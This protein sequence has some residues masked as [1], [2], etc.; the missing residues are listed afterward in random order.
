MRERKSCR[1][2]KVKLDTDDRKNRNIGGLMREDKEVMGGVQERRR[3][4]KEVRK[5][6]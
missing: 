3:A 6:G 4:R 1:W 5:K 2:R